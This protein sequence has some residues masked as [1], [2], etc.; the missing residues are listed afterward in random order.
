MNCFGDSDLVY[1]LSNSNRTEEKFDIF[2]KPTI[3]NQQQT[4]I[5]TPHLSTIY[6]ETKQLKKQDIDAVAYTGNVDLYDRDDIRQQFADGEIQFLYATPV[7]YFVNQYF[8]DFVN[9]QVL[10]GNLS[11]VVFDDAKFLFE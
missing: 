6:Y 10:E 3:K 11:C 8:R 2:I 1:L 7:M 5:F 4:I 9:E